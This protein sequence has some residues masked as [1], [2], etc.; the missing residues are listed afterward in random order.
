MSPRLLIPLFC[1]A[2]TLGWASDGWSYEFWSNASGEDCFQCHGDFRANNYV[3][4]SDGTTW[5]RLH[6]IH[7]RD[8]VNSDCDTC[9]PPSGPLIINFSA[10]G[11]GF[12]EAIGCVGCHGRLEDRGTAPDDCVD[13]LSTGPCGDGAGLRQHHYNA[14]ATI[15]ATCHLDANPL[16]YTPV[17][18]HVLPSY[19]HTPTPPDADHPEKPTDPCN[20][21][22]E[23]QFAGAAIGLDN[24]GDLV[25]D[26]AD[27]DCQDL[28]ETECFDGFDNDGDGLFD[29]EDP[30][31]DA[32]IGPAT[33]CGVGAC[34]GNTGNLTCAGGVE[35]DNCDPF[36]GA[37][38]DDSVC[39]GLDDD[40]DGATD[41]EFTPVA[42]TCGVGECAGN[43][44]VTSC[45]GGVEQNSWNP[46]GGAA[47][48][49]SLCNGLDD[50]CDGATDED[51]VPTPTTCGVGACSGNTGLLTCV[52]GAEED[53]CDPL[54]GAALNDPTCD[55]VDD[56]CDGVADEDYLS[57]PTTCGV[58][59]CAGS[60]G[61]TSCVSG[62]VEDS[63]DPLLG[64]A[65]D[66]PTCD[67]LDEDCDGVADEDYVAPPTTCGV[68]ECTASGALECVAGVPTD[69]CTPGTPQ[70]ELCD[71]LDNNCDGTADEGDPE[72]GAT[73]S[74]GQPGV[75]FEGT[76]ACTA[77]TLECVANQSPSPEVCDGLDYDCNGATDEGLGGLA[78]ST[79]QPGVCADGTTSCVGG[80]PS[81]VPD[82]TPTAEI[83]DGLD[84]NCDGAV[85]EGT[86]GLPCS[87]GQPGVCDA[88]TS[89]C[90]GGVLTCTPDQAPSAEVCDGLDN[91][92]DGATDEGDPGGGV[93][94]NTGDPFCGDGTTACVSG[95]V[96]CIPDQSA[97]P[98][99]CDGADN[100]CDG[101]IDEGNPGGGATCSTGDPFCG[102]G[103]VTCVAG[104]LTCV[105][106][107]GTPE[108]CDGVDND[109]DGQVDEGTGGAACNTG[110][111]GECAAG[112]E[113]CVSGVLECVLDQSP[114]KEQCDGLDNDCDGEV[115]EGTDGGACNTGDP[116]V[117]AAGTTA[118]VG[119]ALSCVANQV[120]GL[121]VCDGLDNDCDGVV[122][123]GN[124]GGGA[125]CT[126]GDPFCGAGTFNCVAGAIQCVP[127]QTA[128]SEVCDGVDNDC[129]GEVDE[130]DPGAGFPCSS[131][132]PG[133]CDPG[134]TA[135]T[136]GAVVCVPNQSAGTEV[137]D[138][139]DNDCD[140]VVDNL[141]DCGCTGGAAP[142]DEVC[143]GVDND[144]DGS[145]DEGNPGGGVACDTGNPNCALG[146]TACIG[147]AVACVSDQEPTPEVCDGLDNDC[148]GEVD[149]GNPGGGQDCATGQP[150]ICAQG[151]RVCNAG[152]F[153]CVA[154]QSP[155]AELCDGL[156][157]NCNGF[158][159]EGT[160]GAA[161]DTGQLG[162]CAAG[163]EVCQRG[164][165][166]CVIN[167]APKK[168]RCDGV[169]NDCDGE[170][171]EGTD[172][173][174]CKTGS[175]GVCS[176]GTTSCVAGVLQCVADQ[177]A[178]LEVCDGLDNDCDGV[179]DNGNP[180][181]GASCSTGEP[182]V[183]DAG[184]EACV[185][186][187]LQCVSNEAPSAELCDGIDNDCD[188]VVD[189]GNPEGGVACNTGL[190][191]N[192]GIGATQCSSGALVC[193][194][195]PSTTAE[196]CD[197]VDNDCDGEVDEGNPGG[198][199][200]CPTGQPGICASGTVQCTG[201]ALV[202]VA[203]EAPAAEVCDGID[204]NCNGFIDEGT[205]GD[206]C[207]TGYLGVCAAGT[208]Y[209]VNGVLE[210][211]LDQ[212]P[213]KERC[214]DGLDNDCDGA[215]DESGP[216]GQPCP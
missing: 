16:N 5:G 62:A 156:D 169:D 29:C 2:L 89:S 47:A 91:N 207:D 158:T 203:D 141:A 124:P 153:D 101:E 102:A 136:A 144:C 128:S 83:C 186:G 65:P 71:G 196:V 92:C 23:E 63:C 7:R 138:Q 86:D 45:V 38:A 120:P 211:V 168:E 192:C 148:D 22:G 24:D 40:C 214:G 157:N 205:G 183:C 95:S 6:D 67:G 8:M 200:V 191:D 198:G 165:L 72:G 193:V 46:F 81:C 19:Y 130:G 122:D 44:G 137:C 61:V 123:N 97:T 113:F 179:V 84:N 1:L 142:T 50:D 10:G 56:D 110:Y 20:G 60:T 206:A 177:G 150:G 82:Q 126:T 17:G 109:C 184:T 51:F 154:D 135:C 98:E 188:G 129:D 57:V 119:G 37:A 132:Q 131:G 43:T 111:P 112:T 27:V 204:N 14:G 149:E 212:S 32:A 190:P 215:V 161:C 69:S 96:Q 68:G 88:G 80:V 116:G 172:G 93:A 143:D 160:G 41:E 30:D 75:C 26:T 216:G 171:D 13:S 127:D 11:I 152:T 3:S 195:D 125:S 118:C 25:Y 185:A 197:G 139:I 180:G 114:R 166:E 106:Q 52:G 209:C 210:C 70:P 21:A 15:C 146:T 59:A 64:A 115:D 105:A 53:S 145:I 174:K 147:G 74:T 39:N 121:E 78:C 12:V 49:D 107:S 178:G 28:P 85:D 31:C 73:C 100:D 9:H 54:A 117:C 94:C 48:D 103:T 36:A 18:E 55:G 163:T 181:G 108:V 208:N 189:D 162:V 187:T 58:G 159:D 176:A 202:C 76:T 66:D 194:P 201:G 134:T 175:P 4:L 42:T 173:S 167:Q 90:S 79:G 199:G 213:S 164:V 34:A 140:G 182:G 35:V 99:V 151:T 170:V 33:T 77:G 104:A 133:V 155:S 87:T